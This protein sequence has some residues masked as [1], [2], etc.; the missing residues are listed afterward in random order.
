MATGIEYLI[1]VEF[2]NSVTR[3]NKTADFVFKI[4]EKEHTAE[5]LIKS[6]RRFAIFKTMHREPEECQG[7][8]IELD[9][10]EIYKIYLFEEGDRN[11]FY[12]T[13][14]QMNLINFKIL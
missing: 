7:L 12:L 1:R 8:C 10:G 2:F 13:K 5:I 6:N 11:D 9:P 4:I 3:E 14:T